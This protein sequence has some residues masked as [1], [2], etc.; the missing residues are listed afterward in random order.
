MAIKLFEACLGTI[1]F[2][3]FGYGL[4]FGKVKNYYGE[5]SNYFAAIGYERVSEDNYE[6]FMF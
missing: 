6:L 1:G 4:A 5:D 2:W 3:L